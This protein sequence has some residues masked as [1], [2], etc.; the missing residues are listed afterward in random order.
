VENEAN[1]YEKLKELNIHYISVGHRRSILAYHNRVLELQGL[2]KW[3][4]MP[5]KEYDQTLK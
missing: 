2:G 1:L 3:R 5:V 4:V